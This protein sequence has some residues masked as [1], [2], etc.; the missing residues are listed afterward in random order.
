MMA[1][2]GE[3]SPVLVMPADASDQDARLLRGFRLSV[4]IPPDAAPG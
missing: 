4:A 2:M 1:Q 3:T